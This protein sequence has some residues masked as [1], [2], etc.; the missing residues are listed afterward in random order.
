[1]RDALGLAGTG[2]VSA[3]RTVYD[4]DQEHD[5]HQKVGAVLR[6][7]VAK[8]TELEREYQVRERMVLAAQRAREL[9]EKHHIDEKA[10][11]L[12]VCVC[13]WGLIEVESEI[14]VAGWRCRGGCR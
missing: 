11:W 10:C 4:L 13:V 8:A 1:V 6:T 3:A 12:C 2:L 7:G 9:N 14:R 5:I